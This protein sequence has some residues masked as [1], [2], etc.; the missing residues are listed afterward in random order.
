MDDGLRFVI[1]A[2]DHDAVLSL[3]DSRPMAP[4]AALLNRG[5]TAMVR[6]S[7]L[8]LQIDAP[9]L[10]PD[11]ALMLVSTMTEFIVRI[12]SAVSD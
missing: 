3:L 7:T 9:A 11:E 5:G 6:D 10:E 8:F 4:L 1:K 2:L 12:E